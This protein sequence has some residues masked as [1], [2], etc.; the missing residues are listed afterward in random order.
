M[1]E[2]LLTLVTLTLL[3]SGV[4]NALVV[5]DPIIHFGVGAVAG[6]VGAV[7]AYPFDYIKSQLQTQQGKETWGSDGIQAF[8]DTLQTQ[9]P[10]RLYKGVGVQVM[11]VAP[12]KGIKL[13]VNDV[14][15]SMFQS[16]MGF[17]PLWGQILS[18]SVAGA[19]Q[20]VASSP[21]EVLKV[22]L[23][24]SDRSLAEVWT[25]VGGFGGLF[26]GSGAC[27]ARDIVFTAICFP[28]YTYLVQELH[29]PSK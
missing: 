25:E 5:P 8:K 14:L 2:S 26:R 17:F 24:T 19:C 22:G 1:I 15:A 7:A 27:M 23:Q 6:G 21:L 10:L 13:G 3:L 12:E 20:I 9:G 16:Q 4:T 28:L 11:G 18:G 29:M